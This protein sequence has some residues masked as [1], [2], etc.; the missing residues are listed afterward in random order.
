[1]EQT[2]IYKALAQVNKEIGAIAKK[3]K[4]RFPARSIDQIYN[5]IH[6]LF[7][8]AEIV[9]LSET[10]KQ[11][12]RTF[13]DTR[14]DGKI[15]R[16]FWCSTTFKFTFLCTKDGS[17]VTIIEDGEGSD[18]SD[19]AS[20]KAK[21]YAFKY[22][23]IRLFTIPIEAG[24]VDDTDQD[25]I[26]PEYV[27]SNQSSGQP[28]MMTDKQSKCIHAICRDMGWDYKQMLAVFLKVDVDKVPSTK[29][30]T[31]TTAT[32]FIDWMKKEQE[33]YAKTL[34]TEGK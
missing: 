10:L 5:S 19:K 30:M 34:E 11:D 9:V 21:S 7:V 13:E 2:G 18:Y 3:S 12:I 25:D 14:D 6:P 15:S 32:K 29:R 33:T 16:L 17:E 4:G 24:D 28:S 26:R 31:K 20:G 22:A 1:M 27:N 23:I 8:D